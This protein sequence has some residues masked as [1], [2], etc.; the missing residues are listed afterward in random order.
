MKRHLKIFVKADLFRKKQQPEQS[1]RRYFPK[2]QTIKN[3]MYNATIKSQL[4][5]ID[6]DNVV[7]MIN[8][9]ENEDRRSGDKFYFRRYKEGSADFPT[10]TIDN[11]HD[12][13][14]C[15]DMVEDEEIIMKSKKQDGRASFCSSNSMA[16][17]VT[18]KIWTRLNI[19]GCNLQDHEVF[20]T[21]VFP[22]L[23]LKPMLITP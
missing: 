7:K 4:S 19:S 12:S 23:L 22:S 11:D 1:N 20:P 9:W 21:T 16:V 6:Q 13:D 18:C 14:D 10:S 8:Q 2:G 17:Q 5:T 3:H 15:E